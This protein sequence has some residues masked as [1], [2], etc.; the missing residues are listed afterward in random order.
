[1]PAMFPK[2]LLMQLIVQAATIVQVV[3]WHQDEEL[4][5]S[6]DTNSKP[7]KPESL[8]T[9]VEC[10]VNQ[11]AMAGSVGALADR[12]SYCIT[13]DHGMVH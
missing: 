4:R 5:F 6:S 1:M 9:Y 12:Q 13:K 10:A 2:S 8:R 3:S 11:N 7:I